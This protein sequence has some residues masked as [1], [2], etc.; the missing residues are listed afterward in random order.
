MISEDMGMQLRPPT[1]DMAMAA[2]GKSP[3]ESLYD[4]V[5]ACVDKIFDGD[6]IFECNKEPK[7]EVEAFVESLPYE[8]FNKIKDYIDALPKVSYTMEFECNKCNEHNST[9]IEGLSSF[10]T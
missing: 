1:Y 3:V 7:Q 10:F 6:E 2:S 9:L 4:T 8:Y 5:I